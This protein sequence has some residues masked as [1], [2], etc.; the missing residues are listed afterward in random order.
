MRPGDQALQE[1]FDITASGRFDDFERIQVVGNYIYVGVCDLLEYMPGKMG[2][3]RGA[4]WRMD[5]NG[6]KMRQVTQGETADFY[7]FRDVI[8]YYD[9]T[10][11]NNPVWRVQRLD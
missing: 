11:I 6:Q 3:K 4:V 9:V 8:L 10:D 2:S 1:I 5:L 7:V